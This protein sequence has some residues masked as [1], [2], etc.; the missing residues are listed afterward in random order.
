MGI[1]P[2]KWISSVLISNQ[3]QNFPTSMV[4]NKTKSNTEGERKEIMWELLW[5]LKSV[6]LPYP[7]SSLSS[8]TKSLCILRICHFGILN[9][10]FLI[11]VFTSWAQ[12]IALCSN[13]STF[14][15]KKPSFQSPWDEEKDPNK[16]T[17]GNGE[18]YKLFFFTMMLSIEKLFFNGHYMNQSVK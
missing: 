2:S 4:Y 6:V 3:N 17:I 8:R 14:L 13:S 15:V 12:I 10:D 1:K 18:Y 16:T 11:F 9:L 7:N 5:L